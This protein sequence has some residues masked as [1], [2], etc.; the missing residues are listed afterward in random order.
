MPIK[1]NKA[2]NRIIVKKHYSNGQLAVFIHKNDGE[3]IAELSIN[4]DSI[5]LSSNEIVLKYYDENSRIAQ[6]FLDSE[7]ILPTDRFILIGSH[8]CPIC[9]VEV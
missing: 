4:E 8:L 1:E 9:R 2:K 3:P 5:E 6:E 7:L